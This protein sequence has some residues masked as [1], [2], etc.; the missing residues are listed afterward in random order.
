M[1][2][3]HTKNTKISI[4]NKEINKI[5]KKIND[6]SSNLSKCAFDKN[7]LESIFQKKQTSKNIIH[8]T[9]YNIMHTCILK[10]TKVHIEA[11]KVI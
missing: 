11:E 1:N 9:R 10:C 8:A 2:Q 5:K 6:L 3:C 4:E 7:E